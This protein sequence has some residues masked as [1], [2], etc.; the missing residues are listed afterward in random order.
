MPALSRLWTPVSKLLLILLLI[1][2]GG[3]QDVLR[4]AADN[5][6]QTSRVV[7]GAA[8]LFSGVNESVRTQ[9]AAGCPAGQAP[10]GAYT[11]TDVGYAGDVCIRRRGSVYDVVWS[12]TSGENYYGQ[13]G[14]IRDQLVVG[15]NAEGQGYGFVAYELSGGNL[16]GSW[17]FAA[18]D[19]MGNEVIEGVP[20]SL[21]GS[22]SVRGTNPNGTSY[23]GSVDIR[24][25]GQ[26]Y[27]L[28]WRIGDTAY[29]GVGVLQDGVLA[30]GWGDKEQG[31]G[32]ISYK[33]G[34]PKLLGTWAF[35]SDANTKV[36]N[37]APR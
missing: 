32:V 2:C 27:F 24:R 29:Q 35:L 23:T 8:K 34:G 14:V 6:E 19:T 18:A 21:E 30:V 7:Q 12:L 37:L 17:S 11:V 31:L 5:P 16:S 33:M 20:E 10:A 15:F 9:T 4:A 13:G 3:G 25:Q 26:T 28:S 22:F 1:G 36:E